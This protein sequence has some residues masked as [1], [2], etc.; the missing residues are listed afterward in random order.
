VNVEVE[1]V[2]ARGTVEGVVPTASALYA[3]NVIVD[4]RAGHLTSGGAAVV[5]VGQGKRL[6]KLVPSSALVREGDL[7][8]VRVKGADGITT[9]WI[10]VGR[11][12]GGFVEVL[13]GLGTGAI[14]IVPAAT[15]TD[16]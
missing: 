2:K 14:V 7:T 12:Y 10:R 1:G 13:A 6:A 15:A 3:V 11:P 5:T 16:R 9:R 4:N 8:G